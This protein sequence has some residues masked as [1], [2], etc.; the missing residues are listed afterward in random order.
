MSGFGYPYNMPSFGADPVYNKFIN[1]DSIET[2]IINYLKRSKSKDAERIW[3][4]LKYPDM[5]ALYK[6]NLT[7]AEKNDLI[8][9]DKD[10]SD[11]RIFNFKF[12]E[13]SFTEACSLIKIY[14]QGIKP[15]NHLIAKVGV[16]F[17]ILTHNKISNVYN[18]DG[19]VDDG[20]R[21]I[22]EN[23]S[24]KNRSTLLLKCLISVLNGA[25]VEGVGTLVFD[26][27]A[28]S[29]SKASMKLSN[30]HND[31]GFEFVMSV[32]MAGDGY[33]ENG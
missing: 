18:D 9:I 11:K 31:Y 7:P 30:N 16:G 15:E 14:V 19:D 12:I 25:N 27:S 22:E 8:Y 32:M 2:R 4:L 21:S 5:K 33:A 1:L 3:K 10:E 28:Y 26:N 6:D 23:I 13:D 29:D 24:I 20:G 17:E